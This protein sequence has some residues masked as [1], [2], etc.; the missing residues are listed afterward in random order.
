MFRTALPDF[1]SGDH[2]LTAK[3]QDDNNQ[4]F[5]ETFFHPKYPVFRLDQA[6]ALETVPTLLTREPLKEANGNSSTQTI[7]SN[8]S[9]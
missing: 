5:G 6:P 2:I 8:N 9:S 1:R 3:L 4:E 7:P